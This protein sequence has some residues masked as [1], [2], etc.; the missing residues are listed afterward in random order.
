MPGRLPDPRLSL[1]RPDRAKILR[2]PPGEDIF[3][4]LLRTAGPFPRIEV[5]DAA[6]AVGVATDPASN[7]L[8]SRFRSGNSL[9]FH[10]WLPHGMPHAQALLFERDANGTV[11]LLSHPDLTARRVWYHQVVEVPR[12]DITDL[13]EVPIG[14]IHLLVPGRSDLLLVCCDEREAQFAHLALFRQQEFLHHPGPLSFP[15]VN[16]RQLLQ[17]TGLLASLLPER[18]LTIARQIEIAGD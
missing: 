3:S 2:A 10:C 1:Y 6:A 11:T 8:P 17:L 5:S 18:W 4:A 14:T 12:Y 15:S 13:S 7:G 16:Q 9:R